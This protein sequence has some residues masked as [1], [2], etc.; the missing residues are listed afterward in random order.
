ML[1][2]QCDAHDG[3]N[4]V[5]AENPI[6]GAEGRVRRPMVALMQGVQ[7]SY[8]DGQEYIQ[9]NYQPV[10]ERPHVNY[11]NHEWNQISVSI[12]YCSNI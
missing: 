7:G 5:N 8:K 4:C 1:E 2:V 6:I 10:R 3:T 9:A 11:Y 12:L